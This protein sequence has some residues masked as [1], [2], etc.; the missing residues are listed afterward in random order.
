MSQIF[1]PLLTLTVKI[2]NTLMKRIL[3]LLFAV[4]LVGIGV[5]AGVYL[6]EIYDKDNVLLAV[7]ST[8]KD[9]QVKEVRGGGYSLIS[10]LLECEYTDEGYKMTWLDSIHDQ[11]VPYV[12][13]QKKDGYVSEASIYFRDLNNGPWFGINEHATFAPASLLKIP[14]LIAYYKSEEDKPGI[15][16]KKITYTKTDVPIL[17]QNFS[18]PVVEEGKTYTIRELID[19]MIVHSDNAATVLLDE[20]IGDDYV[21]GVT[22]D[23]GV[24]TSKGDSPTIDYITVR[25]YASLYRRLYNASYLTRKDSNDALQLLSGTDFAKGIRGGIPKNVKAAQK[26]GERSYQNTNQLHDCGIVYYPNHPYLLCIMTRGDDYN[27]LA[28]FISTISKKI[29]DG[30]KAYNK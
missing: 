6:G 20:Y 29:Y 27:Y 26:Y 3:L 9:Q 2:I 14:V 17:T 10:P 15:F 12:D 16:D 23:L 13:Q 4:V 19:D 24:E 5:F 18:K 22:Q 21:N 30:V 28:S 11:L 7:T 25:G 1:S 8:E